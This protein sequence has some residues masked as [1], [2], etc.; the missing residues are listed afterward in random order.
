MV[1]AFMKLWHHS[2]AM[3]VLLLSSQV[4]GKTFTL[5]D[6]A[7]GTPH[8]CVHMHVHVDKVALLEPKKVLLQC[9]H[10]RV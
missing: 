2:W 10:C 7:G 6:D 5:P 9:N 4:Q 8:A 3:R 1:T